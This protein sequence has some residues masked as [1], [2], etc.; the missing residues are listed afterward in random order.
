LPFE[1]LK[2]IEQNMEALKSS[3]SKI[4]DMIASDLAEKALRK[5]VDIDSDDLK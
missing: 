5:F 4:I 2:L 1:A 3:A